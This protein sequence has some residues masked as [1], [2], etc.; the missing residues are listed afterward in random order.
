M[1]LLETGTKLTEKMICEFETELNIKLPQGYKDFLLENNGGIPD[2][3]W[4]FDF[5]DIGN[6]CNDT[7]SI[8]YFE[9]IYCENTTEG[10]DI[11]AGY[12]ALVSSEQIPKNFLPIA[13]DPFGNI[14][15]ICVDGEYIGN[16]FLGDHELEVPETGYLV[17]SQIADSFL[18]FL[19]ELY[20]YEA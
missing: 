12:L 4:V 14:V 15:F 9:K 3:N 10:D 11:K 13:D 2:G 19:E 16:V 18:N 20:L 6:S 1:K 7:S 17:M 5:Y 8:K